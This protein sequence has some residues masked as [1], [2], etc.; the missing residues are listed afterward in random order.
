MK[1][2]PREEFIE[3]I[4]RIQEKML[5]KSLDAV[6]VHSHEADPANVRYVS[7][8]WP[9]FESAGVV[10]PREGESILL[11]GPESETYA[12]ARSKIGKVRKLIEY[13]ESA[14][15]EYPGVSV[16]TFE[17]VFK[18]ALNGRKIEKLGLIGYPIMPI[19]IY[20]K[21]RETLPDARIVR[22]DDIMRQ[23]R[24]VKSEN[25]VIL[26]REAF[27]ISEI[28][29]DDV[30][31]KIKPGMTELEVVGIIQESIYRNGAEYEGFP[32]YVLSGENS[33]FAICRPSHK[34]LKEGDLVQ[35]D[36]G[37]RVG[38][39]SSSIGRPVSLGKMSPRVRKLVEVCLEAN[40]ETVRLMREGVEAREVARKF[41]DFVKSK[42]Y[43]ENLLYG[44]CHG[45][46]LLETEPP[47]IEI[48][49]DY[50]LKKNMTF[51]VDTFLYDKDFGVR[52]EDGVRVT[53][54]GAERYSSK[55]REIIE[56][57]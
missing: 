50:T 39:Y 16:S 13:R 3:R 34:V 10:I 40:E 19:A 35:L 55:R 51:E 44:P 38:G 45:L 14:E 18:E 57:E 24:S 37:A 22:V 2:I 4:K 54:E 30:I 12:I 42:G 46:G 9:I 28:A 32:V 47:W 29:L 23:M 26:Q 25:E 52:W 20:E 21:I 48:N 17:D 8:F 27:R 5:E 6:V 53:R 43:G 11:V 56:I 1:E 41:Y 7:D 33:S 36:I 15:P 31:N 49:S